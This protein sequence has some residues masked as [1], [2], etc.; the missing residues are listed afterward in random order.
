MQKGQKSKTKGQ[1]KTIK[2]LPIGQR[3]A[4]IN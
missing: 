2:R 4:Y 1:K 3:L